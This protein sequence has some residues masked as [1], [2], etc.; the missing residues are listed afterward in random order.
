MK[1]FL[2]ARLSRFGLV[3][4]LTLL[5]FNISLSQISTT[6][7]KVT[8]GTPQPGIPLSVQADLFQ[9]NTVEKI[10]IAFRRFGEQ[11]FKRS[12]MSLVGTTANILLPGEIIQPPFVEYYF[13]VTLTGNFNPETYPIENPETQPLKISFGSI[14]V[15]QNDII[16]LSP[17]RDETISA[18]D[19]LISFSLAR[20]DSFTAE[21]PVHIFF[22]E[23]DISALQIRYGDLVI[24]R[25][26]NSDMEIIQGKHEVKINI[27]DTAGNIKLTQSWSFNI[28]GPAAVLQTNAVPISPWRYSSSVQL[29]TRQEHIS[30]KNTPYNRVTLSASG[31]YKDFEVRGF[32]FNTNEEKAVR[33][34]QNRYYIIGES[35]WLKIGYGDFF[36]VFPDLI[37]NGKRVRGLLTNLTLNKFNL[38]FVRGTIT[39]RIEGSSGD[40]IP[41]SILSISQQTDPTAVFRYYD[42]LN[43]S[44]RWIKINPGTFSRDIMVVRPSFGKRHGSHWGLTY[45]KSKDD[46]TSIL[47][48]ARPQENVVF[49]SD[50]LVSIDQENFELTG[51][52]AFSASNKDITNGSFSDT[53]IDT[54]FADSKEKDRDQMKRIRDLAKNIITVNEN[55]IP[56]NMKHFP[57]LSY[58]TGL[59]LN[60]FGNN[61]RLS[62]IRH[63]DGYESFGQTYLRN[64]IQGY[65]ISDRQ[66]LL[67][68]KLFISAGYENMKDNTSLSKPAT[69]TFSSL[70]TGVSYYSSFPEVP[71]ISIGYMRSK[72][73]N[74]L[75]NSNSAAVDEITDRIILQFQKEFKYFIKHNAQFTVSTSFRDD[76]SIKNLDTKNNSLGLSLMSTFNIPLQTIF[77]LNYNGSRYLIPKNSSTEITKI[78][79]ISLYLNGQYRMFEDKLLLG[80]TISPTFGDIRRVL[81]NFSAQHYFLEYLSAQ[82]ALNFYFN[83][84]IFGTTESQTD[85]IWT[86]T[87]R[88]AI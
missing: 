38:D 33:Q 77:N 28:E 50:L 79:Y 43:G 9:S 81:L 16:I 37:M 86:L 60:Y 49:G 6:I 67:E 2:Y 73:I 70:N 40:P 84:K 25:P 1:R 54:L 55:L 52:A 10:E 63:G 35:P 85:I 41:D 22:D 76:N 53:D 72:N 75:Q 24:L 26:Q 4:I 29:E 7:S 48:G 36:P 57:T 74:D 31:A 56:L 71:N 61:L 8:I 42:S 30:E 65:T 45:L 59:R 11:E 5:L 62:Y 68:N 66:R 32:V 14:E 47:F 78:S 44:A 13:V 15:Q 23:K 18:Q 82:T 88:A 83:D 34:P 3:G 39:R 87:I 17:D 69:T 46:P 51:Q 27:I 19:L 80:G 12:E 58:E 21:F 20:I 64:D